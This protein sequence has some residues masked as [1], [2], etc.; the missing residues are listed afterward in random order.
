MNHIEEKCIRKLLWR[1]RFIRRYF[2]ILGD[3]DNKENN[4]LLVILLQKANYLAMNS[5]D[6]Q[7][8]FVL[9]LEPNE[10]Q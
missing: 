3:F 9:Q 1:K 2:G 4:I 7:G 8:Y 6:H 10:L 5:L